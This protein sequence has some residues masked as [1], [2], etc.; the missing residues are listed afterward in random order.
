[1]RDEISCKTGGYRQR[2]P[3]RVICRWETISN[4]WMG[5]HRKIQGT[6]DSLL[7][8]PF[9]SPSTQ[10]FHWCPPALWPRTWSSG[11]C[12]TGPLLK[13][14]GLVHFICSRQ[15]KCPHTNELGTWACGCVVPLARSNTEDFFKFCSRN[16]LDVSTRHGKQ[17]ETGATV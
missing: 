6:D 16:H 5:N 2:V 12:S 13:P 11:V 1:M 8:W 17:L 10:F 4:L 14:T 15:S 9:V 7:N 3:T